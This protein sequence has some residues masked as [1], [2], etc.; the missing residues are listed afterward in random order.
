MREHPIIYFLG[1]SLFEGITI[2][3]DYFPALVA[4]CA[5]DS[6]LPNSR[7]GH[8]EGTVPFN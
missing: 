4:Y 1:C 3:S 5:A 6:F 8:P 7:T 2:L